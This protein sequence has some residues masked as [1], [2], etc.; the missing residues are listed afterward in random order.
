[1]SQQQGN[2]SAQEGS[3]C[4]E[5][6]RTGVRGRREGLWASPHPFSLMQAPL[7]QTPAVLGAGALGEGRGRGGGV[8]VRSRG[9]ATHS[10]EHKLLSV[11]GGWNIRMGEGRT[12]RQVSNFV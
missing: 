5:G 12:S 3:A 2:S 1:M 10:L 8:V 9:P 6:A 7:Q 4:S 11:Q